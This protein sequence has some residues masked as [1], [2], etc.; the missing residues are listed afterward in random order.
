MS[1]YSEFFLGSRADV[2]QL[3][4]F[5]LSHPYFTQTYR[6]VRNAR[7]G[8]SETVDLSPDE[9][10]VEFTYYPAKVAQLGSRDDLDFGIRIDVGEVGEVIPAELDAVAEAGAFRIKPALR[11]WAF[12]SDDLAAPIFGPAVLEVPEFAMAPEGTS[13]VARAPQLN[14]NKTGERQTLD[15]FPMQRGFL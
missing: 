2:I 7:D 12:R 15:R 14:A 4:L 8:E 6:I 11:Y 1:A 10:A 5:E 9:L 13:L 3:E